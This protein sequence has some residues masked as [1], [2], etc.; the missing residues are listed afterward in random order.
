MTG[1]A[2][3]GRLQA[4]GIEGTPASGYMLVGANQVHAARAGI[5]PLEDLGASRK[6]VF[7]TSRQDVRLLV[8]RGTDVPTYVRH[9]AAEIGVVGKDINPS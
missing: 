1:R 8:L 5:E 7:E 2:A 9:G 6:L 3:Q 4:A